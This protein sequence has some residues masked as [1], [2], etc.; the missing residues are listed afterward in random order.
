MA[1]SRR[2]SA[3]YTRKAKELRAFYRIPA[4][5]LTPAKK[6]W[7]TIRFNRL[8]QKGATKF[9]K[10]DKER[11]EQFKRAGYITTNKGVFLPQ[12]PGERINIRKGH[13]KHSSETAASKRE[14]FEFPIT[15]AQADRF[16]QDPENFIKELIADN[17]AIFQRRKGK[18]RRYR[19]VFALGSKQVVM[20]LAELVEYI[21]RTRE[22]PTRSTKRDKVILTK[23]QRA[24][25]FKNSLVAIRVSFFS[26][27]GRN[28][29]RG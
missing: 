22:V 28:K 4:G 20:G 11:R 7:L 21:R 6:R 1:S 18:R 9:H 2:P 25:R 24:K 3:S 15:Q 12:R 23:G 27:R 16:I 26:G 13:I 5:K 29:R 17:P 14:E 19:L 8:D 10:V